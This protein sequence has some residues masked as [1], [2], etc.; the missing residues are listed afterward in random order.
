[1]FTGIVSGIGRIVEARPLGAGAAFGKRLV[2]EVPERFL[3]DVAVGDSIALSGA[4]M[5]AVAIDAAGRRFEVETSAESL[6]RTTGLDGPG[7][8]VNLEKSLRADGRLDGHLVSGHVDGVGSVVS[9]DRLGESIALVVQ[10]P[11]EL[12]RFIAVKGSIALD[13]VSLTVNRVVDTGRGCELAINLI[14]HT[15]A[16]TTLGRLQPGR[17]VNLE[18]DTVARYVERMLGFAPAQ[19]RAS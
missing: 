15:A 7:G 14:A 13:G 10:A 18:I 17:Q 16:A 4:C 6:A 2:I 8:G 1:M 9:A 12:A 19:G 5:T 3:D 11:R